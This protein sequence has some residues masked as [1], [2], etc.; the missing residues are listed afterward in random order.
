MTTN[1][2]DELATLVQHR[3]KLAEE[4]HNLDQLRKEYDQKIAELTGPG[5]TTID[6]HK[7]TVTAPRRLNTKAL[8]DAYPVLDHPH[9]YSPK[10]DTKK[11]NQAFAPDALEEYKTTGAPQVR[12]T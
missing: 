6:D 3:L 7:I 1:R 8:E 5:T 2:T 10:L 11:V 9:L 12:I 4:A